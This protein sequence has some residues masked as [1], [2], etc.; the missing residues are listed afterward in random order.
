M[1]GTRSVPTALESWYR[2][3][4]THEP[5]PA[6][7]GA[8]SSLDH[9]WHALE[10]EVRRVSVLMAD[11]RGFTT[12][13]E[14][15]SPRQAALVLSQY[16][17]TMGKVILGERGQVQDFFGDGI[18]G[19]FGAPEP[20]P[21]HAWHAVRSALEMQFA[22]RDLQSRW[23]IEVGTSFELGVA[24]HTGEVYA[25]SF[26][27]PRQQKYA[28]VGDPV[29]TVAR[30]EEINRA[31][32]TAIVV[33][34]NTRSHLGNRVD[35]LARGSFTMR[36]RSAPMD[37]FEVLGVRRGMNAATPCLPDRLRSALPAGASLPEL[38]PLQ[39]RRQVVMAS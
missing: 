21:D 3:P 10:G 4:G 20:D 9:S 1:N 32:N 33:S 37:V 15:V 19:V 12:F 5:K 2:S 36:G 11:L 27:P 14:R 18:L 39:V 28:V 30:L 29:N 25:A 24:V 34:G 16:L 35:V 7:L 6:G 8:P 17:A 26:G 31:L 38:P 22:I 13:C 23:E